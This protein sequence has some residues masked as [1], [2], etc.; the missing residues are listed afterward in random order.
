MW[1]LKPKPTVQRFEPTQRLEALLRALAHDE[2]AKP[3]LAPLAARALAR[4]HAREKRRARQQRRAITVSRMALAA[5][6]LLAFFVTRAGD[7]TTQRPYRQVAHD[8]QPMRVSPA[9][10]SAPFQVAQVSPISRPAAARPRAKKTTGRTHARAFRVARPVA[11]RPFVPKA[12]WRVETVRSDDYGVLAPAW[13]AETDEARGEVTL[14][15]VVLNI[16]IAKEQDPALADKV[17][18]TF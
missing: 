7:G 2:A 1:S 6:V 5:V 12:H 18:E 17:E 11:R 4:Q 15:P 10:R 9:A 14:T 16:E 8:E 3:A 13:L